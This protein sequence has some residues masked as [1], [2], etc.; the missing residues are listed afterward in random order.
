MSFP[1]DYPVSETLSDGQVVLAEHVNRV[2]RLSNDLAQSVDTLQGSSLVGLD[3]FNIQDYGAVGDGEWNGT[4]NAWESTG[5]NEA[6]NTAAINAAFTDAMNGDPAQGGVIYSPTGVYVHNGTVGIQS[7]V[8]LTVLGQGASADL[9]L[10]AVPGAMWVYSGGDANTR[11]YD[12]RN[13]YGTTIDR[14][15]MICNLPFKRVLVD[16][17]NQGGSDTQFFVARNSMFGGIGS[18]S[19]GSRMPGPFA[20]ISLWN[21]IFCHVETCHFGNAFSGV[22]GVEEFRVYLE[23]LMPGGGGENEVNRITVKEPSTTTFTITVNGQTTSSIS[24]TAT[25]TTVQTALEALSNVAPG[26]V[27]VTRETLVGA[28]GDYYRYTLTWGGALANS[29]ITISA[30]PTGGGTNSAGYSNVVTVK[31]NS[32]LRV[33]QFAVNPGEKWVVNE[34][35]LEGLQGGG[36][37][38]SFLKHGLTCDLLGSFGL[39]ATYHDN[40]HGD[41]FGDQIWVKSNNHGLAGSILRNQFSGG[42]MAADGNCHKDTASAIGK[43]PLVFRDN[44]AG[45]EA[46]FTDSFGSNTIANYTADEGSGTLAI[47]S[48]TL[49]PSDTTLKRYYRNN[50][51][52]VTSIDLIDS[53]QSLKFTPDATL[54]AAGAETGFL[55]KRIDANNYIFARLEHTS[56]PPKLQI[57][58]VVAGGAAVQIGSDLVI[59]TTLVAST[60]YWIRG[61]VVD[62]RIFAEFWTAA[63]ASSSTPN[64]RLGV[65]MSASENARFGARIGAYPGLRLKPASTGWTYDDY[66]VLP[67][68]AALDIG[69]T[70]NSGTYVNVEFG[71]GTSAAHTQGW[72]AFLGGSSTTDPVGDLWTHS[73]ISIY[74]TTP[75][76]NGVW[77]VKA[78]SPRIGG[79]S[80]GPAER[81][82]EAGAATMTVG[83]QTQELALT[84]ATAPTAINGAYPGQTLTITGDNTARTISPSAHFVIKGDMLIKFRD[85]LTVKWDNGVW[86]EQSRSY[87]AN[88]NKTMVSTYETEATDGNTTKGVANAYIIRFTGARTNNRNAQMSTVNAIAGQRHHLVNHTTGGF[89]IV[90]LGVG[91]I[92]TLSADEWVEVCYDGSAWFAMRAGTS[93]T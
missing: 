50:N 90:V 66:V 52:F 27:T 22:R 85:S 49:N 53:R 32:A 5:G 16:A 69:D 74:P 54:T 83:H 82:S 71:G 20:C 92:A 40:W 61:E 73:R 51:G 31:K 76:G 11:A 3:W 23:T 26:D 44:T 63:P 86:I 48:G 68:S 30:T 67:R 88:S 4:T 1:P 14:M 91:T 84:G 18:L 80:A 35:G 65:T 8:G 13:S 57:F 42:W 12:F 47:T 55:I 79:G 60:G 10:T 9:G 45:G 7:G 72:P 36:P 28:F 37:A 34:N 24:A 33:R 46:N 70:T 89:N 56:N 6:T 43:G 59:G 87:N 17:S 39:A 29:D 62:D 19:D 77:Q 78:L 58:K 2:A 38:R 21:A 81:V 15:A 41:A 64:D 25:N 93:A 75:N